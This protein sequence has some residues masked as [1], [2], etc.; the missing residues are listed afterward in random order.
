[1]KPTPIQSLLALFSCAALLFP[2]HLCAQDSSPAQLNP[3]E[4]P[5]AVQQGT[6]QDA[7]DSAGLARMKAKLNG[8]IIPKL[9]FRE[10]TLREAVKYL[11]E[12]SQALDVQE[13]N[14]SQKGVKIVLKL[15][16]G[17][18]GSGDGGV[19][20][21]IPGLNAPSAG[22]G[23]GADHLAD[24]PI[25]MSLRQ[26]P[27]LAA[28]KY[29]TQ[30]AGLK[31]RIEPFVVSVV[32]MQASTEALVTKTY[33]VRPDFIAKL[34]VPPSVANAAPVDAREYLMA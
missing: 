7:A 18:T 20:T 24:T 13:Q 10:A 19:S 26:V 3:D 1:M 29:V 23:G 31:F 34:P 15:D 27:L 11:S 25:T 9:E 22:T 6:V 5:G 4:K 2:H 28:L 14:P 8:I 21:A 30:I 16:S 33:K 32:P 17:S 12:V